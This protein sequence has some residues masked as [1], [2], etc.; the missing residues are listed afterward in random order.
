MGRTGSPAT[1]GV[2][3]ATCVNRPSGR[4]VA[5]IWDGDLRESLVEALYAAEAILMPDEVFHA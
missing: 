5:T 1:A 2:R 3:G 4:V